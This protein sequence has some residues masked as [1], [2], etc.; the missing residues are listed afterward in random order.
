MSKLPN[1]EIAQAVQNELYAGAKTLLTK[2]KKSQKIST[3]LLTVLI[4]RVILYIEQ[5]KGII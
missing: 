5:E 1:N 3:H 2:I 4:I